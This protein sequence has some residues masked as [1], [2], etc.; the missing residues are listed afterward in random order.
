MRSVRPIVLTAMILLAV[1]GCT[2]FYHTYY[3]TSGAM[4]PTIAAKDLMLVDQLAYVQTPPRRGD[5]VVFTPPIPTKSDFLK[6]VIAVPGDRL[7]LEHGT[8]RVNGTAV[9][10][11][12]ILERPDYDIRVANWAIQ[13]DGVALDSANANVPPRS[14]WS[15]ADRLPDGCFILLGDNRNDSEDSH[16]WGCSQFS[17]T[18]FSGPVAGQAADPGGKVVKIIPLGKHG[19]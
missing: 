12:Y 15:A 14:A 8:L 16:I 19:S 1:T 3:T 18:F 11:P 17:G 13:V 6:R 2:G 7:D 9:P 5:I 4:L 10:E